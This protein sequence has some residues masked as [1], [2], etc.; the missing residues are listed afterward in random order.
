M[1]EN[2]AREVPYLSR[3]ARKVLEKLKE[4]RKGKKEVVV[5]RENRAIYIRYE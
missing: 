3:E 1:K 4:S 5:K 2:W